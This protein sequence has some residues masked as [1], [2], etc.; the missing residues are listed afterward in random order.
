MSATLAEHR[1][2]STCEMSWLLPV[3]TA[4][5][6]CASG[7]W[8]GG[9]LEV[10][11]GPAASGE[12]PAGYK[13]VERAWAAA[14]RDPT[15][16]GRP[17]PEPG[18]DC[19]FRDDFGRRTTKKLKSHRKLEV[20]T[21]LSLY[22]LMFFIHLLDILLHVSSVR[23]IKKRV[24]CACPCGPVIA[25]LLFPL[26]SF[27]SI[28]QKCRILKDLTLQYLLFPPTPFYTHYILQYPPQ[29]KQMTPT[30]RVQQLLVPV[31]FQLIAPTT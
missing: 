18:D 17:G 4:H 10:R 2:T 7:S 8:R 28:S 19:E 20:S 25:F 6:C 30:Q 15:A 5:V 13:G 31:P 29:T 12:G 21:S 24:Q 1:S 3:R 22:S 9:E 11:L 14:P 26:P 27:Y 16:A 23:R